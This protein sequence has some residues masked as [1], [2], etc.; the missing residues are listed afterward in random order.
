MLRE[1]NKIRRKI[2][3]IQIPYFNSRKICYLKHKTLI[4][5]KKYR[6]TEHEHI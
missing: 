1:R 6:L 3:T 5:T 4:S 2:A